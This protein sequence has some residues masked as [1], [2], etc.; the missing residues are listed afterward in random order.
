MVD[1]ELAAQ[2]GATVYTVGIYC[3]IRDPRGDVE[4]F[5]RT[6]KQTCS[7]FHA[8][9]NARVVRGRHLALQGS[10]ARFRSGSTSSARRAGTRSETSR[11]AWR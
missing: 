7:D 6:V 3:S 10:R 5:E 2:I 8:L 11:T 1:A 4:S 9:T